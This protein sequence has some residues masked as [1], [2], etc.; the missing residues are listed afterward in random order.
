[1]YGVQV[2]RLACGGFILAVR[3]NHT[4]ADGLGLTQFLGAVAELARGAQTPSVP[5]VWKR[6]QLSGRNQQQSALGHDKLDEVP[7]SDTDSVMLPLVELVD[8]SALRL[9]YFFFGPREIAAI[10]AQLPP[11]LQKRATKF[12][13]IAGWIWKFHTVA[14]APKPDEVMLLVVVVNA[15][16]RNTT[17]AGIPI[18]Y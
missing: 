2:T 16:G 5:L 11:H 17:A 12:D 18:G 8:N 3:L 14:L 4:M 1:M 9:H 6:K 7:G 13:T 10:R 15:R